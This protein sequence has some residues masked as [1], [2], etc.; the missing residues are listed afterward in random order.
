MK[1]HRVPLTWQP[2]W[3]DQIEKWTALK[4][5]QNIWRFEHT[6]GFDD[7]MQDAKLLFLSLAKVYSIVN[8]DSHF[9]SLY[10]T[11]LLRRFIDKSRIKTRSPVDYTVCSEDIELQIEGHLPNYGWANVLL[12]EMPSELKIVL[13]A[14]T[15]GR[16]RL[17]LDR[18]TK[19]LR[20]RENLNMRLRR[21][22]SLA[23]KDPV[24]DL[25]NYFLKP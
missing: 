2:T 24:G 23:T 22:F 8:K 15:S 19:H 25:K 20:F 13:G 5:R 6:E 21:K 18:P 16:V 17:K 12:D 3:T 14:L 11:S 7:V 4:I 9:F 10:K 1:H